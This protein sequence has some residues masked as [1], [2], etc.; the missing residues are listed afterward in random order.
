M[1]PDDML[2]RKYSPS[3]AAISKQNTI[4]KQQ[5]TT[6]WKSISSSASI[7]KSLIRFHDTSI[8]YQFQS[9]KDGIPFFFLGGGVFVGRGSPY[10][11]EKKYM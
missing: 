2:K 4:Q 7:D 1:P 8:K 11:Y 9:K 6:K 10:A 3:E 5:N